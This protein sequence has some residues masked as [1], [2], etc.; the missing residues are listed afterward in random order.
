MIGLDAARLDVAAR[1]RVDRQ[2]QVGLRAV[3]HLGARFERDVGVVAPR[4]DHFDAGLRQQ[5]LLEAVR[6]VEHEPRL[7]HPV[8]LRAGIV[9]A[10]ARVDHDARHLQPELARHGQLAGPAD[11]GPRRPPVRR[12]G[13]RS[14]SVSHAQRAQEAAVCLVGQRTRHR[15]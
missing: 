10:V 4:Q 5:P 3:R 11:G 8:R 6:D 7:V 12:R 14:R 13:E 9:P 1:V 2:E 15:Q